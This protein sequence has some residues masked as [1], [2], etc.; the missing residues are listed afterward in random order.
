MPSHHRQQHGSCT[1]Q[2]RPVD[3]L[4]T[5]TAWPLLNLLPLSQFQLP[6]SKSS[7]GLCLPAKPEPAPGVT[8]SPHHQLSAGFFHSVLINCPVLLLCPQTLQTFLSVLC[9]RSW[10]SPKD[11]AAA[12]LLGD[13]SCSV[14][15]QC[16]A[17][18]SFCTCSCLL[19]TQIV[20]KTYTSGYN[21]AKKGRGSEPNCFLRR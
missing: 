11:R 9:T 8:R 5:F 12:A 1:D 7:A 21:K 2:P 6:E 16:D 4:W 15:K 10:F 18:S 17:G 20:P 19:H 3:V 13:F 14:H